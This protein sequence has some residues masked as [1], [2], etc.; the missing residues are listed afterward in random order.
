MKKIFLFSVIV[1]PMVALLFFGLTR[2]PRDLPSALVGKQAPT[3]SLQT[4]EGKP[5]SLEAAK[6]KTLVLNFWATWCGPCVHEHQVIQQALRMYEP[7]GVL[8]YSVLYEDSVE[9]A[10]TFLKKYGNAAPVLLDPNLTAAIDYGV[11]GIPETFFI[12]PSGTIFYKQAGV[13]SQQM[14]FEQ[15]E[16]YLK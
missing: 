9:N 4:L 13:L 12:D 2:N 1:I 7:K 5:F 16:P 10:K 3:F 6:G 15:L 14:L 8:F 11:A